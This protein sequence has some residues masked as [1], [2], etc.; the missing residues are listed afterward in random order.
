M[1]QGYKL[2]LKGSMQEPGNF[3]FYYFEKN[4]KVSIK[5]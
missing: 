1:L 4:M 2:Q 3:H 5:C